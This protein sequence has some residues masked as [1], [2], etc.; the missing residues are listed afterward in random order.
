MAKG[1]ARIALNVH[2]AL[3]GIARTMLLLECLRVL[4][5]PC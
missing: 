1:Q 5:T 4:K 2:D 3:V